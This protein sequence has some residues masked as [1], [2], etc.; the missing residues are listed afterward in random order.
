MRPTVSLLTLPVLLAACGSTPPDAA[1]VFNPPPVRQDD[2]E[3][4]T[5]IRRAFVAVPP[6]DLLGWLINVPLEDVFV[7]YGTIPA[8]VGTTPLS[9]NWPEV[10][11]RRRL[12]LSDGHQAAE[13]IL[14][15]EGQSTFTYQ[16]W[17]FTNMAGRLTD[18]AIGRF[19]VE[20]AD[21]GAQLTWTYAFVPRSGWT[22]LPLSVFVATQLS[23][24]MT[25]AMANLAD[26]AERALKPQP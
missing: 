23:G 24:Y 11:A 17:G 3:T 2:L 9:P 4:V 12:L 5:R 20:R 25:R 1:H 10:G 22:Q 13:I 15:V 26:G 18:Y 8:V 16:V 21:G 7:S 19:D 6:Q 14:K